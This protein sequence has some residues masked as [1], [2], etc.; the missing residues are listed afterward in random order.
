MSEIFVLNLWFYKATHRH[1]ELFFFYLQLSS[2][3]LTHVSFLYLNENYCWG[4]LHLL[5][6]SIM[7]MPLW[8]YNVLGDR[9]AFWKSYETNACMEGKRRKKIKQHDWT[10]CS[11]KFGVDVGFRHFKLLCMPSYN[12]VCMVSRKTWKKI[13]N[14]IKI[15]VIRLFNFT[16]ENFRNKIKWWKTT[17]LII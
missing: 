10:E 14:G 13:C 4:S 9:L 8:T 11:S 1:K 15:K 7:Y 16:I 5:A 3:L 2:Q 12:H 17:Y 6:T